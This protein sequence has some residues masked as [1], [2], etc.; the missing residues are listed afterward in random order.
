MVLCTLALAACDESVHG[1]I[2]RGDAVPDSP[3]TVTDIGTGGDGTKIRSD[4]LCAQENHAVGLAPLDMLLL[5]DTS[6]SMDFDTKWIAV[7]GATKAFVNDPTF[8]GLGVG[9]QYFPLPKICNVADYTAAAVPFDILPNTA[10]AI[11]NSLEAQRMAGGTPMVPAMTGALAYC[12]GWMKNNPGRTAVI[13][14]ATDGIPDKTCLVP[15]PDALPNNLQN[16][17]QLAKDGA[18]ADPAISTFVI[19]VGSE[20]TALDQIAVAGGTSKAILLDVSKNVEAAFLKALNDIRRRASCEFKIP[21]AQG[22]KIDFTQVEIEFEIGSSTE[23][24]GVVKDKQSCPANATGWYYDKPDNP[25]KIILCD[26]T[27]NKVQASEDGKL[28]IRFGCV[29]VPS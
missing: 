10:S 19:G 29:Y 21:P 16:A 14:L 7:K 22:G 17:V 4:A 11:S 9:I 8:T 24:F 3:Q 1:V 27:C 12:S 20:L 5:L 6:Y 2:F 25:T 28:S 18:I 13:V 23:S 15:Q 26:D